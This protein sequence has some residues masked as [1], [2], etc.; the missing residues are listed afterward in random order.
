MA[1]TVAELLNT[2]IPEKLWH[3]TSIEGFRRIVMGRSDL[4]GLI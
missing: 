2:P 3:Y 4:T 1:I